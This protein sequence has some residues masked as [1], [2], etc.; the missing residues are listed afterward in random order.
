[1]HNTRK[2]MQLLCGIISMLLLAPG[3]GNRLQEKGEACL[4]LGDFE[5]SIVFFQKALKKNPESF[6]V[7]YGLARAFLQ[8]CIS[9]EL[10]GNAA[11]GHWH[12]AMRQ[13]EYAL[14]L[15]ATDSVRLSLAF[16]RYRF[17]GALAQAGD[18]LRALEVCIDGAKENPRNREIL[19]YAG[20]L[21]YRLGFIRHARD[22]FIQ[23]TVADSSDPSA[24]FNLGLV[25]WHEGEIL[26]ARESWLKTLKLN[27]EDPKVIRWLTRA[28]LALRKGTNNASDR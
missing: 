26:S 16:A 10:E 15:D 14:R 25:Q 18:S 3:C 5:N 24:F 6:P 21:S 27:P 20:I 17:A 12:H 7:R 4:A 28:D 1:M 2:H 8:Q 22:F 23:S 9:M 19:N 11:P 13:F